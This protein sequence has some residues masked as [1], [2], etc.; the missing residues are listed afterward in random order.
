ESDAGV[1]HGLGGKHFEEAAKACY[2]GRFASQARGGEEPLKPGRAGS[3][4][5]S[6]LPVDRFAPIKT[7]EIADPIRRQARPDANRMGARLV[8]EHSD[9]E[10][11]AAQLAAVAIVRDTHKARAGVMAATPPS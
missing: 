1:R 3:S 9:G 11:E 4:V 6:R 10:V 2:R 5:T 8:R 7:R